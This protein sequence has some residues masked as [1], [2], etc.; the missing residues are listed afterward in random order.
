MFKV[1]EKYRVKTGLFASDSSIGNMGAFHIPS[2]VGGRILHVICSD[3]M[4]WD[5]VS[6]HA[7]KKNKRYIPRWVEMCQIKELFWS[8]DE[9]VVQFHPKKSEYVNANPFVL[10]LWR[11][12]G[13]HYELPPK[14]LI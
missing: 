6:V 10:H 7:S 2:I 12:Q 8:D 3:E 4:G 14:E 13:E 9:T 11:K 1:P 5:H